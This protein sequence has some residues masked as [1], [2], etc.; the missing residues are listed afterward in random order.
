[1]PVRLMR[2]CQIRSVLFDNGA[3]EYASTGVMRSRSEYSN[4]VTA[5]AC[6]E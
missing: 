1:M 3:K 5:C 4:S 6:L 2:Q